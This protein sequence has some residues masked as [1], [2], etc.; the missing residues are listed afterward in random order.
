MNFD[1]T[2]IRAKYV[3]VMVEEITLSTTPTYGNVLKSRKTFRKIVKVMKLVEISVLAILS[4]IRT[5]GRKP[6]TE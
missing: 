3:G 4:Q 1:V 5:N 2:E 6:Y